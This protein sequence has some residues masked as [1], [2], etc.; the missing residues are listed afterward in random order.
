MH[1]LTIIKQRVI[2][3]SGSS[4]DFQDALREYL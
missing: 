1:G 2:F 3:K 4:E